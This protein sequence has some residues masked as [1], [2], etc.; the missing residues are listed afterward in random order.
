MAY[1]RSPHLTERERDCLRLVARGY[2]SKEIAVELG[3]SHH[4]VDLHL[5]RAIKT[6][7]VTS[8]RDAARAFTSVPDG[9]DLPTQGLNT[10]S[11]ALAE[12]EQ[13]PAFMPPNR[14]DRPLTVRLPFLRQGRQYND[15]TPL[16]RLIWIPILALL[17]LF[18]IA[19]FFNGLGALWTITA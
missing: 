19:N 1:D 15:L 7:G 17:F 5:R 2:S 10:Q 11:E 12:T 8:R 16:Q 18:V 9:H 13:V 3:I 4:T 14:S 6:L